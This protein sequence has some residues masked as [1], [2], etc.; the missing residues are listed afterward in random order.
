MGDVFMELNDFGDPSGFIKGLGKI[1]SPE[2][3]YRERG[4]EEQERGR[5]RDEQNSEKDREEQKEVGI[6]KS[7]IVRK[8]EKAK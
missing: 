5:D 3:L 6:E 7:G 4:R 1:H 8:T 2:I